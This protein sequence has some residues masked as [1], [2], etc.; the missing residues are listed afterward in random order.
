MKG[1]FR[2]LSFVA[3]LLAFV[4]L[5]VDGTTTISA[6]ELNW[7]SMGEFLGRFMAS[8]ALER[9]QSSV[10][11]NLHPLLWQ[12]MNIVFLAP[13]AVINLSILALVGWM[14]GRGKEEELAL[15]DGF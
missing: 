12:A 13:P 4:M 15:T 8:G 6:K 9:L 10:S 5:I 7:T 11:R 14:I 2:L 1:L 3:L